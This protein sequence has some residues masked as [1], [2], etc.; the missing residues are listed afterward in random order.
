[1][2]NELEF[3]SILSSTKDAITNIDE[4]KGIIEG[5]FS[6]FGNKDS[7]EDIIL[8]GAY[9]KTLAENYGRIKHLYQHDP[10]RPLSG[11]KNNNLI[12]SE[13]N[14]GLKFISTISKTSYGMDVIR[15]H[16]D[17][18]IDEHS[19][20]FRTIRSADKGSYRELIEL[21]AWEGSS[22]TWGANDM[23]KTISAKSFDKDFLFKKMDA[24]TKAIRNGKYENEELFDSLEIYFKQ[25]QTLISN[26]TKDTTKPGDN[27]STSPGLM[28]GISDTLTTFTNSLI[29]K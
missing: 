23:A 21:Q 22:V 4:E 9:T 7:D 24:V 14:Y 8:P 19:V 15:L 27:T 13:D 17:G 16:L 29:T 5:Y 1:M 25:L 28:K 26:L 11:T 6:V 3:K 18:V 20:G 2:A 12:L 10:W